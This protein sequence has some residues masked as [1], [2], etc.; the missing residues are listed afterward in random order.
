M[1][2]ASDDPVTKEVSREKNMDLKSMQVNASNSVTRM[3]K[4][5][6]NIR[7]DYTGRKCLNALS[8]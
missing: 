8:T 6:V 1:S 4:R 7:T 5:A 2:V 3:T